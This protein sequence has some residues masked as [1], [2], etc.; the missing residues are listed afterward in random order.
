MAVSFLL[1]VFLIFFLIYN[2]INILKNDWINVFKLIIVLLTFFPIDT[3]GLITKIPYSTPGYINLSLVCYDI[4]I[5]FVLSAVLHKKSNNRIDNKLLL[6]FFCFII[7][8]TLIRFYV[9][10]FD[11]LSNKILDNIIVPMLLA[12]LIIKYLKYDEIKKIAKFLVFCILINSCVAIIEYFIGKSLFF[13]NY[14]IKT[15]PWYQNIYLSTKYGIRFRSSAFLGHPLINGTYYLIAITFLLYD[16]KVLNI[17]KIVLLFILLFAVFTTNS[18][19]ALLIAF[20]SILFYSFKEKKYFMLFITTFIIILCVISIDFTQLYNSIFKRDLSGSSISVRYDA[21]RIFFKFSFK[22][23]LLGVGFNNSNTYL[24]KYGF[25]G[26]LEIS[27]LI[28]I[29]EFGLVTF[30]MWVCF[31]C[32]LIGIKKSVKTNLTEKS[33]K[34]NILVLLI[35][36]FTYN[37]IA[38]PGTLNYLLFLIIAMYNIAKRNCAGLEDNYEYSMANKKFKSKVQI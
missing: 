10:G 14:Y 29:L 19:A 30:I 13:H 9:D 1:I 5:V 37:S 36:F 32:N 6:I 18:R 23:V 20:I 31:I 34:M 12:I 7:T 16:N 11:F 3:I 2:Y 4:L 17:K 26:N 38:D 24:K 21:L 28:M 15:I 22:D 27:Y 33:L 8:M 25:A 35:M